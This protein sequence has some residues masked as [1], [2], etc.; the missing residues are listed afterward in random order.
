MNHPYLA[1]AALGI[2]TI[3]LATACGPSPSRI[4]VDPLVVSPATAPKCVDLPTPTAATTEDSQWMACG[5]HICVT[6]VDGQDAFAFGDAATGQVILSKEDVRL[7]SGRCSARI[8]AE[9]LKPMAIASESQEEPRGGGNVTGSST[10]P[11]TH[12][13][14]AMSERPRVR[15]ASRAPSSVAPPSPA[16][17]AAPEARAPET[18]ER[19]PIASACIGIF[20]MRCSSP[21]ELMGPCFGAHTCQ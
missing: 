6:S 7:E 12:A 17:A 10:P 3:A 9:P 13:S 21:F 18:P 5:G 19:E 1:I 20:R 15:T 14:T 16:A 2:T 4:V 8:G 11:E